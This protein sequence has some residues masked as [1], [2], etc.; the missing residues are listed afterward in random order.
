M[1]QNRSLYGAPPIGA[2]LGVLALLFGRPELV[3]MFFFLTI[4]FVVGWFVLAYR[5]QYVLLVSEDTRDA[6]ASARNDA[7]K[8][9]L[10][11]A[12]DDT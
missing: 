6:P 2:L 8:M 12:F 10:R 11:P 4:G 7:G 9:T 5:F 1:P 3:V